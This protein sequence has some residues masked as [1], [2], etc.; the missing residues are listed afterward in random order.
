[1]SKI[2]ELG[3]QY[4]LDLSGS[5]P[6]EVETI[7][8]TEKGVMCKYLSSW[9]GRTEEL[10]YELFEMNGYSKPFLTLKKD[11]EASDI[12]FFAGQSNEMMRITPTG[13]YW[14]GKLVAEDHEI[15]LKVK[16]FF[17]TIK[18]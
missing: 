6:V 11:M 12:V 8:F 1:M 16:E 15:Y 17:N 2:I 5:S 7:S 9:S 4:S 18:L 3:K 13:F 10:G 14:K